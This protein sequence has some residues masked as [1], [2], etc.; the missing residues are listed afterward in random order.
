VTKDEVVAALR[1]A[2]DVSKVIVTRGGRRY[3]LAPQEHYLPGHTLVL[4]KRW[5][6]HL[7][8]AE[9]VEVRVLTRVRRRKA[10]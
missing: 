3:R 10:L 2:W 4:G 1:A 5:P 7:P 8:Y 6:T 9:I